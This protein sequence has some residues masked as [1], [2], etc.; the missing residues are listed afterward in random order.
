MHRV[1]IQIF[2]YMTNDQSKVS[3]KQTFQAVGSHP[4][5]V[6]LP[7]LNLRL[8]GT[9]SLMDSTQQTTP[10]LVKIHH[11]PHLGVAMPDIIK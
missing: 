4:F 6:G 8:A 9:A 11:P 3:C 1:D 2:I 5:V 10:A 7:S